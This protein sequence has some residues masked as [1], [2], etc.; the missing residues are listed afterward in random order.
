MAIPVFL[1]KLRRLL[2]AKRKSLHHT[3]ESQ[4][5]RKRRRFTPEQ[6]QN[7]IDRSAEA[8]VKVIYN[9][10]TGFQIVDK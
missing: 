5:K 9:E 7:V 4:T 10:E 2:N 6:I 1:D 8:G 3:D